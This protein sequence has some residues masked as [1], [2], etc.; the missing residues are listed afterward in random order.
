MELLFL[1]PQGEKPARLA[2]VPY[3]CSRVFFGLLAASA[4]FSYSREK[5]LRMALRERG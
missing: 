5:M 1:H 2:L 4:A 3:P